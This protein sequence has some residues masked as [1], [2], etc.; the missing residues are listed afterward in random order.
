MKKINF[1]KGLLA[2]AISLTFVQCTSDDPIPGPAGANGTNGINGTTGAPGTPGINGGNIC[3]SCHNVDFKVVQPA[4]FATSGHASG[5]TLPGRTGACLNCHSDAGYK[6]SFATNNITVAIAGLTDANAGKIN[7]TT[8]HSGGHASAALAISGTDAALRSAGA[9]RLDQ[10][11]AGNRG[12]VAPAILA[13]TDII[14]DY[15]NNSNNC[16]HCHQS[17]RNAVT[18]LAPST[19]TF[20]ISLASSTGPHYG[21]QVSML[22][23]MFGAEITGATAYPTKGTAAHRTGATCTQCH[24]GAKNT[25]GTSGNHT[26]IPK[27]DLCKTCHTGAGVVDFNINGGQT[28]IKNLRLEL[29]EELIRVRP[30][31]FKIANYTGSKA[32]APANVYVDANASANFLTVIATTNVDSRIPAD[33]T[34]AKGYW[35][36]KFI[37]QDHSYGLHNPKYADALL[38]NTIAAVKLL[39]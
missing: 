23:G 31:I 33:V 29:A 30:A 13:G 10:T 4:T 1:L 12:A 5:S 15:K 11:T 35:N 27:L 2:L 36:W 34:I 39:P 14:I 17:R 9:Y 25:N 18:G 32:L 7:C 38:R 8:C 28:K 37:Y 20:M 6:G 3:L 24:M 26:M 19:T 16:I 21:N 22:E